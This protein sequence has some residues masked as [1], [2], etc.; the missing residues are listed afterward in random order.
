MP[1]SKL[2]GLCLLLER[3]HAEIGDAHPTAAIDHHVGRFQVAVQHALFVSRGEP[4]AQLLRQLD[5]FVRRQPA[6]ASQ[7][8]RQILAVDIFHR[9]ELLSLDLADVVD[10]A[11]VGVAHPSRQ[12]HLVP[13]L[14]EGRR[15][16]GQGLGKKLEGHRLA[17]LQ[18]VGAN[19]LPH[20]TAAEDG[21]HA[22]TATE[23]RSRQ[24]AAPS[25]RRRV[26]RRVGDPG[27]GLAPGAELQALGHR[28]GHE[29][30]LGQLVGAQHR[31]HLAA[32]RGVANTLAIEEEGTIASVELESLLS[33]LE[34]L[35]PLVRSHR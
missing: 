18:I 32:Q 4:G 21:D 2:A 25:R 14:G 1:T 13:Q 15:I 33:D 11:N 35:L 22:V 19:H 24:E 29:K 10:T 17:E 3:G 7:Q 27:R 31:L 16:V 8:R 26:R 20:A 28:R 34:H 30:R 9:Q 23:R 5:T 12:A 6:D